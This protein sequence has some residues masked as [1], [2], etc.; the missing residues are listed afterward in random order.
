MSPPLLL[1][2][3]LCAPLTWAVGLPLPA[4]D[5]QA[6]ADARVQ[7]EYRRLS[8]ELRSL[9][10]RQHWAGAERAYQELAALGLPIALEDLVA[11]GEAARALG[12]LGLAYER[13]AAAARL[14]G[15]REIVDWLWA[16]DQQYG[17]VRLRVEPAGAAG[18][19]TAAAP[20]ILP[21]PRLC[22]EV[23]QRRLAEAGVFEGLLP[24]G[25]Y[26]LGGQRF[27]VQ[28]GAPPLV[29]TVGEPGARSRR[30]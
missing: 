29:L 19:L 16:V 28:P 30:R 10:R 17:R 25:S 6:P 20:P 4:A 1:S 3:L 24:A 7:A 8:G 27:E 21:E 18:V 5:L 23:A 9:A 14:D 2:L 15:R 12:E 13:L 22:V 11:G 26:T